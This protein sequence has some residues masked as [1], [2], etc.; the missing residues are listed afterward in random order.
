MN[1]NIYIFFTFWTTEVPEAAAGPSETSGKLSRESSEELFIGNATTDLNEFLVMKEQ[2][3]Q[4]H[5][6]Y[7]HLFLMIMYKI[8]G[9]G[10]RNVRI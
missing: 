7:A 1:M 2:V 9:C 3:T 8:G 4:R 10:E 6:V 5:D